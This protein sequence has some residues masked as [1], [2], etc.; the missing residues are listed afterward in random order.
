MSRYEECI[1]VSSLTRTDVNRLHYAAVEAK[2][3]WKARRQEVEA[4]TTDKWTVEECND[5]IYLYRDLEEKMYWMDSTNQLNNDISRQV[6]WAEEA[7]QN[8]ET[9]NYYYNKRQDGVVRSISL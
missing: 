6:W 3:L 5:M 7:A 9:L 2:I 4:G 8:D 1:D